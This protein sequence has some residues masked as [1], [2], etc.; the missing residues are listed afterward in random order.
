M[1]ARA[2]AGW[3]GVVGLRLVLGANP[4]LDLWGLSSG[5]S[6]TFFAMAVGYGF[7]FLAAP[8]GDQLVFFG[9]WGN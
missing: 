3:C 5:W 8:K 4:L 7:L 2:A 1:G 6:P 9:P